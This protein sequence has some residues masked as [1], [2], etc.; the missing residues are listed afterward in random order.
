MMMTDNAA[1]QKTVK[2]GSATMGVGAGNAVAYFALE[3]L[4]HT[5]TYSPDDPV[6]AMAMGGALVSIIFLETRRVGL[7]IGKGVK[8][9]FDRMYPEK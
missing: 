5:N 8:Y 1:V 3:Y 9:V 6:V 2:Y 4:R 7:A